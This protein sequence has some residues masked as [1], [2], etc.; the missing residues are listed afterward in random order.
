MC[1]TGFKPCGSLRFNKGSSV[2]EMLADS[3]THEN[4]VFCVSG[5]FMC[6]VTAIALSD[7]PKDGF[8]FE[9]L[10]SLNPLK[11]PLADFK[12]SQA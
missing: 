2:K 3:K 12:I 10:T 1:P 4:Y 11:Y 9:L 8:E 7:K 6:P 5:E